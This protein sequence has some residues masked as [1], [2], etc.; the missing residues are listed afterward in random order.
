M[1]VFRP[2]NVSYQQSS[3]THQ[4]GGGVRRRSRHLSIHIRIPRPNQLYP[5]VHDV[6]EAFYVVKRLRSLKILIQL[7][8]NMSTRG[9]SRVRLAI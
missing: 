3:Y 5:H 7:G 9:Q 2:I 6:E 4:A 1:Q 8:E